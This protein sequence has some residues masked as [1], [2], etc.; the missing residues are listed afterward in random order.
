MT[1]YTKKELEIIR[2][3]K[4]KRLDEIKEWL[5]HLNKVIDKVDDAF[6]NLILDRIYYWEIE[7]DKL[8]QEIKD[9]QERNDRRILS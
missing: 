1:G 7:K 2:N 9:D 3:K 6:L 5:S 4:Q 8:E